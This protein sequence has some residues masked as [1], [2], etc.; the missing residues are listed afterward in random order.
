M[1]KAVLIA[2]ATLLIIGLTAS[3]TLTAYRL[4]LE[5]HETSLGVYRSPRMITGT[6]PGVEGPAATEVGMITVRGYRCVYGDETVAV[7][8]FVTYVSL[9]GED[10]TRVPDPYFNAN[11]QPRPLSPRIVGCFDETAIFNLPPEVTP[12][13]WYIEAAESPPDG[14]EIRR[15]FSEAFTVVGRGQ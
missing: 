15:W 7:E 4:F 2:L 10:A 13:R 8:L 1:P 3:T 14:G 6:R 11:T 9:G 12:G 5:D